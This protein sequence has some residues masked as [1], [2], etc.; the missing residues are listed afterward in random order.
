MEQS[1]SRVATQEIPRLLYSLKVHCPV[2]DSPPL[3]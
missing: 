3:V 1:P 2:H